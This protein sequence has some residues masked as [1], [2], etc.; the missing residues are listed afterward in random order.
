M[1]SMS[2]IYRKRREKV[3]KALKER[4]IAA[5]RFE[6]FEYMRS[7]AVRYL[8]GHPGDAFLIIG[9]DA[10]SALVAWDR[11]MADR[12]AKVDK[13]YSYTDFARRSESAM[14][15]V[16]TELGIAAG[17]KV[18]LPAATP[19]PSFVDHVGALD[20]WDLVCERGGIDSM[21][22]EMRAVK[23]EGE[24]AIYERAAALTDRLIDRIEEGV[25]KGSLS[26]ELDVALFIEKEARSAGAEGTGFETIA[27]GPGRSFGIHA[28]PSYGAGPFGTKG[29]SILDFGIVVD[30]YTTDVTMSF[31]RGP[32]ASEQG[33]MIQLVKEAYEKGVAAC[34][35]GVAARDIAKKVDEFFAAA[36][37]SMPHALGHS[38]GL[39]A[40][41]APGIN[42]R[43]ENRAVLKPGT[44]VTIE[45]GLYHPDFGGVRLENDVL[46][47][48]TGR[49]VL[50]SSRIVE[51]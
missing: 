38:I 44:I 28:F 48:E 5:A 15:F 13:I 17:Q 45:P 39:E 47:T 16:L 24:L 51:L 30:G 33:R 26:S 21:V 25:R 10:S 42:L 8:C 29:L 27:A 23:D 37:Y 31:A 7:P 2:G 6:D 46:I 1:D 20:E 12:M 19:Y 35:P 22:Q 14:R 43:E 9:A 4:G 34:A 41:E 32:L 49:K 18:E 50:T 11:N 40:H 36:G 3:A